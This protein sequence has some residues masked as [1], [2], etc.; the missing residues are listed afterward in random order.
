MAD[1]SKMSSQELLALIEHEADVHV[2]ALY[3]LADA[4][5]EGRDHLAQQASRLSGAR[6]RLTGEED[7]WTDL[8][9]TA[10]STVLSEVA[11]TAN[12]WNVPGDGGTPGR[13]PG[14]GT[15]VNTKK[16]TGSI[17]ELADIIIR[18][19]DGLRMLVANYSDEEYKAREAAQA[20]TLLTSWY[21]DATANLKV[22]TGQQL[23]ND[24]PLASP[25]SPTTVDQ[26][27]TPS[28]PGGTSP[29]SGGGDPSA[30]NPTDTPDPTNPG[31]DPNQNPTQNNNNSTESPLTTAKDAVDVASKLLDLAKNATGSTGQIPDP[32]TFNPADL[33]TPVDTTLPQTDSGLPGLA[34][35][36]GVPG[37]G[38]GTGPGVGGVGASGL[39]VA[40]PADS[41]QT[42]ISGSATTMPP[43]ATAGTVGSAGATGT[44]GVGTSG[45]PPM[46]PPRYG[47]GG[48]GGAGGGVRS[49]AAEEVN[50]VRSRKPDGK[51]GVVLSGREGQ[52][53]KGP[54]GKG[55]RKGTATPTVAKA[56][57]PKPRPAENSEPGEVL[58]E[59]LWKVDTAAPERGYQH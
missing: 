40:P 30:V 38:G 48:G 47:G 51:A 26:K 59:E 32:T 53:G 2:P 8:A 14:T 57:K 56:M 6:N 3:A 1:Y 55:K 13:Q 25:L 9:G 54:R 4:W 22:A 18:A 35:A 24:V 23:G 42:P 11:E 31:Q 17:R 45:I 20:M 52:D 44:T 10:F 15:T 5:E 58:D 19:R 46:Y 12:T 21:T 37:L 43:I 39:G 33:Y 41:P 36:G 50:A 34:S 27:G 16:L 49:G 29:N 7:G 28:G